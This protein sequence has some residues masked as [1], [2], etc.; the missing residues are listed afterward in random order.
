M[1]LKECSKTNQYTL[2]TSN[3]QMAKIHKWHVQIKNAC[4]IHLYANQT[5]TA[6]N[7]TKIITN[8]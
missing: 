3:A 6:K 1:D 7:V 4:R 5:Q 2:K 8:A